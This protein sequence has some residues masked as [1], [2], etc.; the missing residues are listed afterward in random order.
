MT[1]PGESIWTATPAEHRALVMREAALE[2]LLQ[3]T[4]SA[5]RHG[6]PA[7]DV[8]IELQASLAMYGVPTFP[9]MARKAKEEAL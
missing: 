5:L 4:E 6:I 8:L 7:R 2:L 3:R 1:S 9:E